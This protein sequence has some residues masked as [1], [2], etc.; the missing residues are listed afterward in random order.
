MK[1]TLLNRLL[2][3]VVLAFGLTAVNAAPIP[4]EDV[5]V[6]STVTSE[7]IGIGWGK[8]LPVPEGEWEVVVRDDMTYNSNKANENA[9]VYF[10]HLLNK[11][12]KD[13]LQLVRITFE[14]PAGRITPEV[15]CSNNENTISFNRMGTLEGQNFQLCKRIIKPRTMSKSFD[16]RAKTNVLISTQKT[17]QNY[18]LERFGSNN[19][20]IITASIVSGK[21]GQNRLVYLFGFN[22]PNQNINDNPKVGN[23]IDEWLTSN[24][25]KIESYY[26]GDKI[27]FNGFK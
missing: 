13:V 17:S 4:L 2:A 12:K 18:L 7:G 15:N 26:N 10:I 9:P 6:G 25:N 11:N 20:E 1:T 8:Y 22:L 16:F 23:S 14:N 3:T 21:K 19:P 27:S 24:I 5:K